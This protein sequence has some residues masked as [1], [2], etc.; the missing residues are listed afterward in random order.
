MTVASEDDALLAQIITSVA[1][2][3]YRFSSET[4][5]HDAIAE[6]LDTSSLAYQREFIASQRDRFDFL[7][8]GRIVLEIKIDG[9]LS[10]V[11]GQVH[12]YCEYEYV[13][14]VAILTTKLW[15]NA[16][17]ANGLRGKPVSIVKLNRVAF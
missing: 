1:S 8:D 17:P 2:Y 14:A 5:L 3:R 12:R 6:V 11:L 13:S 4:A 9:S 16:F 15:A 10:Q 7:V